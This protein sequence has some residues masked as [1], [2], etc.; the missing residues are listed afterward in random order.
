MP[1]PDLKQLDE[2][3]EQLLIDVKCAIDAKDQQ[4]I[5][6]Y[7]ADQ[8]TIFHYEDPNGLTLL[9]HAIQHGTPNC[10]NLIVTQLIADDKF[11][12]IADNP[13]NTDDNILHLAAQYREAAVIEFLITKLGPKA[14]ILCQQTNHQGKTPLLFVK[15]NPHQAEHAS[16]QRLLLAESLRFDCPDISVPIDAD[17]VL[18]AF[19]ESK[20]DEAYKQQILT[21]VDAANKAR[22]DVLYST[23]HPQYNKKSMLETVDINHEVNEMRAELRAD[24][25]TKT[26]KGRTNTD[27]IKAILKH[28]TYTRITKA[29]NCHEFTYNTAAYLIADPRSYNTQIDGVYFHPHPDCASDHVFVLS[30]RAK[31]SDKSEPSSYGARTIIVDA[32]SGIVAPLS[33]FYKHRFA[34]Y[35]FMDA[36]L[37]AFP[38]KKCVQHDLWFE[39]SIVSDEQ[40]I[41]PSSQQAAALASSPRLFARNLKAPVAPASTPATSPNALRPGQ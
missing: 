16:M 41:E 34:Y 12:T 14:A 19:P 35:D 21:C 5:A 39:F 36:N 1:N 4:L 15:Q 22:K 26:D 20:D 30:G 18:K 9:H 37:L 7:L 25:S 13:N 28:S 3:T 33:S 29:A 40:K 38:N 6:R 24:K 23:T 31:D 10:I 32:F 2:N 11:E 8:P 27:N 17:N